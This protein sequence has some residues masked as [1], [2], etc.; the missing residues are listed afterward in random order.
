MGETNH[1]T[2]VYRYYS[3]TRGKHH[4]APKPLVHINTLSFLL[5][6][7]NNQFTKTQV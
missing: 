3:E 4:N 7:H 1:T 2:L 6:Q 5:L